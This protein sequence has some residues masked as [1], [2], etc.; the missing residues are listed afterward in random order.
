MFVFYKSNT[1][2]FTTIYIQNKHSIFC[3]I[4]YLILLRKTL[5]KYEW[6]GKQGSMIIFVYYCLINTKVLQKCIHIVPALQPIYFF[7][8][9]ST[10]FIIFK[11]PF[12][13]CII[14]TTFLHCFYISDKYVVI[15]L[16][17]SIGHKDCLCM[18]DTYA[19]PVEHGIIF[20]LESTMLIWWLYDYFTEIFTP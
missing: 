4:N 2:F 13:N 8:L 12:N 5:P 14:S 6:G 15:I 1:N 7:L 17:F 10:C 9:S 11:K 20:G 16:N 19:I 3:R 18:H